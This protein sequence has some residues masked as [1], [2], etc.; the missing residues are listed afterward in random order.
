MQSFSAAGLA[1]GAV[2][3]LI[4]SV[5]V[6]LLYGMILPM[7]ARHPAIWGGILAP[8]LWTGLVWASL[9]I[10]NPA[11]NQRIDW[12]WFVASQLAFGLV[13]G[14]I[15]HRSERIA[16]MQSWPLALRAGLETQGGETRE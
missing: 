4:L 12:P 9:G 5:L 10:V 16:T 8:L 2:V 13:A 14:F 15:V 3:H 6:G 7:F 11:L 1:V